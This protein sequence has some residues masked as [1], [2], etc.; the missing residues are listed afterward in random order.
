MVGDPQI[1]RPFESSDPDFRALFAS[2]IFRAGWVQPPDDGFFDQTATCL[3]G[4]G[5]EDWTREWTSW[6]SESDIK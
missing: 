5:D 1:I 3:G 6:L 4:I 2:P